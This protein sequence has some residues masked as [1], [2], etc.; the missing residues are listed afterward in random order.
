MPILDTSLVFEK[1]STLENKVNFYMAGGV[2]LGGEFISS[3]YHSSQE[4]SGEPIIYAEPNIILC[5][6][7]KFLTLKR[8]FHNGNIF[9]MNQ[10]ITFYPINK[11]EYILIKITINIKL[12][13]LL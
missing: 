13:K 5:P 8:V 11:E 7:E 12:G 6:A 10:I 4:F 9:N 2:Y 1:L 3:I